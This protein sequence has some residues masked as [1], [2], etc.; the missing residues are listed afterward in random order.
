MKDR[1]ENVLSK[2]KRENCRHTEPLPTRGNDGHFIKK[3]C[4][5][6]KSGYVHNMAQG[7]KGE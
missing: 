5:E 1:K 4:T 3:T 6:W 2:R 7:Q